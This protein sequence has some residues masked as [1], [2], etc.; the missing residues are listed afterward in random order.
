MHVT[1]REYAWRP[2]VSF[3]ELFSPST[4]RVPKLNSGWQDGQ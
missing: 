1:Q 4:T 3:Q 2:E